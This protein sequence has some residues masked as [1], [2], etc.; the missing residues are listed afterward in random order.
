MNWEVFWWVIY[1]FVTLGVGR[2]AWFFLGEGEEGW[3]I[4]AGLILAA[5]TVIMV[6]GFAGVV[7]S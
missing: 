5:A 1:G 2:T 6:A 3:E 4:I 7:F